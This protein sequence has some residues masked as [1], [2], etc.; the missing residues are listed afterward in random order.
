MNITIYT[1]QKNNAKVWTKKETT[2]EEF[3]GTLSKPIRT[4]E[5]MV[6]YA[7]MQKSERD[8]IKDVGGFVGGEL[9]NGVR[10][11]SSVL[12][13]CV[14][15]LDADY[16]TN[17]FPRVI[18]ETYQFECVI[19]ST[20]S[21]TPKTPRFRLLI[22]LLR[23]VTPEE[24]SYI[25]RKLAFHIGIDYFDGTS[26]EP[27]RLMYYPSC[28][29]DAQYE[30]YN[31][32]G[33]Y[34]DPDEFLDADWRDMTKWQL[35]PSEEKAIR[36]L[37]KPSEKTG[38]IGAF[39]R[40]Y[41][42]HAAIEKF[43]PDVYVY[44]SENRYS[45]AKGSTL[46]GAVIY[47][48]EHLYSHHSTDP[49]G[50]QLLNVWDLV[51]IHKFH[52]LDTFVDDNIKVT[53]RPSQREMIILAQN[54]DKMKSQLL[55]ERFESYEDVNPSGLEDDTI[56]A[57]ASNIT[58]NQKG[59]ME[60]TINNICIICLT[61]PTAKNLFG[62]DEFSDK[63]VVL[64]ETPWGSKTGAV[65]TDTDDANLRN[66]LETKY[67]IYSPKRFADAVRIVAKDNAF[68]PVRDYLKAQ[69]WDGTPRIERM[70][71]DYLEAD[72]T[73]Y[74]R[75]V[76][77]FFMLGAVD[78]VI[79]PGCKFDEM[80]VLVSPEQ[81]I[82]KSEFF[83]RLAVNWHNDS[84][85]KIGGKEAYE[86]LQGSWFVEFSEL[87]AMRKTEVDAVRHFLTKRADTYRAAYDR[88][89][90]EHP[91][92]CI[93]VGNTNIFEF[94]NDPTGSR[95]FLPVTCHKNSLDIR[96]KSGLCAYDLTTEIVGQLWAEA[97]TYYNNGFT[98]VLPNHILQAAR[99]VQ[100]HHT[101]SVPLEGVIHNFVFEEKITE[102]WEDLSAEIRIMHRNNEFSS[103][104]VHRTSVCAL[105]VCVE[106]L[107][108]DFR[109]IN[110]NNLRDVNN[111]LRNVCKGWV[112]CSYRSKL[113]GTQRGY[114]KGTVA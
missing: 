32:K 96:G 28:S 65:W 6:E 92:Q 26:F 8:N 100:A 25:S 34:L 14:I 19:H 58:L 53:S 4:Y 68:H 74:V 27:N 87:S 94:L 76:S 1:A 114:R 57:I 60:D 103:G 15:A 54:D 52:E 36:S 33:Y 73:E 22:P 18:D 5:T 86:Q 69:V 97:M 30:Y 78:R 37:Q 64:R 105:E 39:C 75:E 56:S 38:I 49:A 102:N 109:Y 106:A 43:L 50:G 35:S 108:M 111:A 51:R 31:L 3:S 93:F 12:N 83:K 104:T 88:R 59:Q 13:R 107:G 81:G 70:L 90:T 45:Y 2:W 11:V 98:P 16:A 63:E 17:D 42:I 10:K 89:V 44:H 85:S 23:H 21:H 40:T 77:K 46:A 9:V 84:I 91:R 67:G 62:Y 72:D 61:D 82:G 101:E 99:K 113:Y 110:K 79:R 95:R 48:N 55:T 71:I 66:L 41:D 80:V 29:S 24:Y 112:Q 20:H 7:N 47:N